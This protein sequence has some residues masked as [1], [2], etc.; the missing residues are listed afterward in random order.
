[1]TNKERF[2]E[3]MRPINTDSSRLGLSSVP[4]RIP[5]QPKELTSAGLDPTLI[6]PAWV[7]ALRG[8]LELEPDTVFLITGSAGG[9]R[10]KV[11]DADLAKR[12]REHE[13]RLLEWKRDG[14]D[15]DAVN[16]TRNAFLGRSR[17]Q[18][19]EINVK[20][21]AQG[22]SPLIVQDIHRIFA[23]DFQAELKRL[24][25]SI[26]LDT[27][28]WTDKQG[29]PIWYTGY[30]DSENAEFSD[31]LMHVSQLQRALLKDR[32][33]LNIFLFVGPTEQ[34]KVSMENLGKTSSRNGGKFELLTTK[35]LQEISK[36]DEQKK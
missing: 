9:Q 3:W 15:I 21:K 12:K 33:A 14:I 23:S 13:Q 16:S 6:V 19:N 20:L 24:G 11:S 7:R 1:M 22:K 5:W 17:T 18:L 10:R 34:P 30:S 8:A 25:Y 35:R 29:R 26:P 32:A 36:R 28:G 31:V 4:K 27:K 2:F